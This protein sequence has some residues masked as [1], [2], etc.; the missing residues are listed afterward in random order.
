MGCSVKNKKRLG[1]G[2]G[3]LLPVSALPSRYGIGTLGAEAR[4]FIRF[5]RQA[6]QKYW[7]VLPVGP[8]S[9][10]DS[11][12][13]SFS[14]F[15]GNPYFIDL[16]ALAREGYLVHEDLMGWDWGDNPASVDY[17]KIWESRYQV[18]HR[19]FR[20]GIHGNRGDYREFCGENRFW[21]DDYALFMAVKASLN[22]VSWQEWPEDIRL[23]QPEALALYEAAL[24][25]EIDFWK[26][27]QYHFFC[28]WTAMKR[29]AS[30]N[31]VKVIGD[32]PIY[33]AL[34][35]AD[36]W[37]HGDLFLLDEQRRPT[38]VAGV[39]PDLF[40]ATGQLWGNPLYDWDEMERE[41]FSWWKRRMAFSA[42][43]YDVI[44][45]DH[46]I[47]V[48][49]YYAIPAGSENAM[50][51]EYHPGPGMKLIDAIDSVMGGSKIIAEDLGVVIPAVRRLLKQS[52][53]PGMKVL[54]FAFDGGPD[55]DHLPHHHKENYVVYGGTHD[56]ETIAGYFS[57]KHPHALRYAKDYYN[58]RTA[59]ELPWAM[60]R[61]CYASVCD[62][63]VVQ[64]QDLLGL[65]N[66]A[67]MNFPSTIGGNWQWRL[68]P[69]QADDSLAQRLKALG[70]TYGRTEIEKGP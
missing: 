5:L 36:V 26:F 6:G 70:Q 4:T 37:V 40:S 9:Y 13:Q 68:L 30:E 55:N 50:T 61:S 56:N 3:I 38:C 10:G 48:V 44:R 62:T 16:D 14:A 8:T 33:M 19:A 28:Q 15:A 2:A 31:G 63:A 65:D 35:S 67:R 25:D 54:A 12:Y 47:G 49:R 32:I 24:T 52:G 7:Q 42:R 41:D 57:R 66:R 46:F 39:P 18:L 59:K 43:L 69:G 34:D 20:A 27:C 64:M 21:L 17:A 1:R 51:G 58:V 29:F 22:H 45:I 11:P 60:V 23:R 53:Y